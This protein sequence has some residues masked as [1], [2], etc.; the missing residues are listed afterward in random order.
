MG[1]RANSRSGNGTLSK[2]K[3]GGEQP[4]DYLY[5][6]EAPVPSVGGHSCCMPDATPMGPFEQAAVEYRNDVLLYTSAPLDQPLFVAGKVTATVFAASSAQDTDFV[7][8][9]C[10]VHPDGR[11]FNLQEGVIRARFRDGLSR[12]TLIEPGRIYDYEISVGVICHLFKPGHRL[13]VQIASSNYPA[14]D[15]NPNTGDPIGAE[16]VFALV[17]AHQTIFHDAERLSRIELPVVD[18]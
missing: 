16:D 17:A 6:P 4:D 7:V 11:S 1:G 10:D 15:R 8:K 13:R 14:W 3:P 2:T 5:S 9:L 12:E 18:G